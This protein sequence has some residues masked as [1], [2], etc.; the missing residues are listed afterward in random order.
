M[1]KYLSFFLKLA[2]SGTLLFYL[3]RQTDFKLLLHTFKQVSSGWLIASIFVFFIFQLVSAFRWYEILK[4][5]GF[6]RDLSFICRVYFIGMFFNAFLPGILGGDLIRVFYVVKEGSSKTLASFSVAYDRAFGF[7]GALFLLIIFVPLEGDFMPSH[8]RHSIFYFSVTV[9]T[10]TFGMAIFSRF[11]HERLG[12]NLAH[13]MTLVFKIRNF[14]KLF[15][16]GLAVQVLYNIHVSLLGKSLGISIPWLKYFLIIPLMGILASLPISLGGFGVRE[17]TLAYF[18]NLLGEPKEMGIALGFLTY[19]VALLGG[20]VG[21]YFYLRG[22]SKRQKQ[23][24]KY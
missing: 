10:I 7:L 6:K 18:L 4:V 22:D 17:G 8:T 23:S 1:K 15:S 20:L 3:F 24:D 2:V 19:G 16:L 5:L 9:L 12:K 11:W 21:G 14:L 13:T